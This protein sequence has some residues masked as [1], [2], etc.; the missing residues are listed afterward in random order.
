MCNV[1]LLK[2]RLIIQQPFTCE[3]SDALMI[4]E[5]LLEI[6][7]LYYCL[8]YSRLQVYRYILPV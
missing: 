5:G 4:V 1:M 6:Q 8:D 7:V 3:S 2:F